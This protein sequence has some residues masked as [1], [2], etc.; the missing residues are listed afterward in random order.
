MGMRV[1]R[2]VGG[3]VTAIDITADKLELA[4]QLG[5]VARFSAA[6]DPVAK[7]M[8]KQGGAH[9]VLVTSGSKAAYDMAFYCVRPTGTLLVVGLPANDIC[10]PPIMMAAGEVRIQA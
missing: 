4:R 9:V 6:T 10:F 5:A 7:A 2:E 8:R 1:G 3:G